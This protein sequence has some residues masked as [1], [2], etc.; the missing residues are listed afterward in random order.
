M[1]RTRMWLGLLAVWPIIV[2]GVLVANE[3]KPAQPASP[4]KRQ[5]EAIKCL[6]GEW[7][8]KA[9]HGDGEPV[10]ATV[11][12]RVTS[13]GNTVMETL[14]QGTPHEMITMYHLDGDLLLLTHYCAA[15]NQPR[16]KCAPSTDSTRLAF[17]FLDGTN[18][19]PAMD[20]HMH[21]ATL[22][23]VDSDH[24]KSEWFL[25]IKGKPAGSAKFD[26]QRKK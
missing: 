11:L 8:G 25:H 4:A 15:G 19:N 18:M 23:L 24:I 5:F 13:A 17:K 10:D 26:L 2:G 3:D 12:Y 6:A 21:D 22:V 16:M 20:M 9:S 7:T 14:F 1:K